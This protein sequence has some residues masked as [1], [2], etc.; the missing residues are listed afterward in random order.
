MRAP[1]GFQADLAAI[2]SGHYPF[3]PRKIKAPTLVVMGEMDEI[4]T[5]AGAQWLLKSL[6]Q[7]PQR[8]LVVIGRSSHTIQFEAERGQLY[9]PIQR[10]SP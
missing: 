3:D 9:R 1:N 6:R 2:A 10:L 5:F 8:R 4:A 7:A